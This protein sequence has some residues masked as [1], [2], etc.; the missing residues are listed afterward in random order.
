MGKVYLVGAGPGDPDL[1]TIKGLK[2][3]QQADVILYDRLVNKELLTHA[4]EG[5]DLIY[6]G[7]LPHYHTMKQETI[8]RFLIKYA[9]GSKVV[10]RLKGGDPFVFGRGGEEAEALAAKSIPFE[11]VPGITSGIAASA[12]AG[13]PVTHRNV[14]ASVAF[15]TGH[16]H[17]EEDEEK[18]EGLAKGVDTLA[19]YMGVGNLPFIRDRLIRYGKSP[20]TPVALVHW[21]T[22]DVQKTVTG[23]LADI[24]DVVKKEGVQNPSM[25][26]VGEVV[27]F[28]EKI[29]WF[30][31]MPEPAISEAL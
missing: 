19:I 4:K 15:V 2:A 17:G 13:I 18:W 24:V 3:I 12:Y 9:S 20:E 1:L 8:N 21:G 25:I 26:I 27:R 5:A 10:V 6:C 29:K 28:R 22:T 7:K 31:N 14:S 16:A 23:T 11:V 30:E